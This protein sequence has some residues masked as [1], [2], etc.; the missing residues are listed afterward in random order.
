[1]PSKK[2]KYNLVE[3]AYDTRIPLHSEEAFQHGIGFSAKYIGTLDVPRPSS[4][5]E[6]VTAMRRIRYEFKAKAIRKKKVVLTISVD[7]IK[8]TLRK[9]KKKKKSWD[10]D[11]EKLLIMHH[12]VY[13]VFYVS[14]DS[15]DLKIFSYIA[16]DGQTNIF[17]CNVFKSHKKSQAMRI[18]RSIGQAF[19]VCHKLSVQHASTTGDGQADGESDKQGEEQATEPSPA[20][21][22]AVDGGNEAKPRPLSLDVT[23]EAPKTD[24][25]GVKMPERPASAQPEMMSKHPFFVTHAQQRFS[26]F[27]P[28]VGMG[29]D[30]ASMSHMASLSLYHQRQLLQQQLQQQEAQT[31]VAL[32]QVQLLKD[33]LSAETSA[34]MESQARIHQLMVHNRELLMHQQE[35]VLHIQELEM[36][37]NGTSPS[38]GNPFVN[39]QTQKSQPSEIT[40][41][42]SGGILL[43]EFPSLADSLPFDLVDQNPEEPEPEDLFDNY[44]AIKKHREEMKQMNIS[45]RQPG[46]RSSGSTSD[47]NNDLF[48]QGPILPDGHNV[49]DYDDDNFMN[50][51][52]EELVTTSLKKLNILSDPPEGDS[53]G[54]ADRDMFDTPTIERPKKMGKELTSTPND[55]IRV[56]VPVP[57]QDST[58]NRLE[59]NVSPVAEAPGVKSPKQRRRHH[60]SSKPHQ[61][62][63]QEQQQQ[64]YPNLFETSN[65]NNSSGVTDSSGT[66]TER[67]PLNLNFNHNSRGQSLSDSRLTDAGNHFTKLAL[68]STSLNIQSP[69]VLSDGSLSPHGNELSIPDTKLHISFSD[70]ENTENSEDSGVPR[71]PRALESL[72][73]DELEV[74]ET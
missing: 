31:Q 20:H 65:N 2:N 8:V 30:E 1:M 38:P 48:S 10:W 29:Y 3:D 55:G 22:R 58:G 69:G 43:P 45:Q 36:K 44:E 41:P 63:Q 61:Q 11:D 51:S 73:F 42:R 49:D 74:L 13:R 47:S 5:M 4:R 24:D 71:P 34:R 62:K 27:V 72:N 67:S 6:I 54:P 33:Q 59:L 37:L 50:E 56:I 7:G 40:T 19:E 32:A 15:Q 39:M 21:N 16:R 26:A 52:Q 14:H 17:K 9:K 12:P 64:Q 35:L 46:D 57:M 18:V 70:D 25:Q 66:L 68:H 60:H 23:K 53:F 28:P